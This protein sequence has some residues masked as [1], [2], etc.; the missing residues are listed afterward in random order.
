MTSAIKSTRIVQLI[1]NML[2]HM[3]TKIRSISRMLRQYADA[4]RLKIA[5]S[6][7]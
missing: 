5:P 2:I 3:F 6:G 4:D 7:H 1:Y